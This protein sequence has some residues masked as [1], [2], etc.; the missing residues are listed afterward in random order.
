MVSCALDL[1]WLC[2][3]GLTGFTVEGQLTTVSG[4]QVRPFTQLCLVNPNIFTSSLVKSKE[5]K[6]ETQA[7]KMAQWIEALTFMPENS[8]DTQRPKT[9]ED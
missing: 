2:F 8:L 3:L 1:G 4:L 7:G 5:E 6:L 9:R